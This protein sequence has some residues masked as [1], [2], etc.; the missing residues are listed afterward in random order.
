MKPAGAA[1][2]PGH[3]MSVRGGALRLLWAALVWGFWCESCWCGYCGRG[4]T[5]RS[6][7]LFVGGRLLSSRGRL[8]HAR[9]ACRCGC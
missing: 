2:A 1:E 9:G 7:K 4:K 5:G 8:C 6:V 3:A